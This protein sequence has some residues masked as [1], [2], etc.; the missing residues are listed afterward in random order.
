VDKALKDK[1]SKKIARKLRIIEKK[2]DGSTEQFQPRKRVQKARNN[3][4]TQVIVIG[5]TL[6]ALKV[7]VLNCK[8]PFKELIRISFIHCNRDH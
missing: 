6:E 7:G 1:V 5:T 3:T 2:Y 4:S 8:G